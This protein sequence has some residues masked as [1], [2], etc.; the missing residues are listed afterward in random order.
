MKEKITTSIL[1]VAIC[2]TTFLTSPT[3]AKEPSR[4]EPPSDQT[5]L[6]LMDAKPGKER[7]FEL[8][9]LF[10]KKSPPPKQRPGLVLQQKLPQLLSQR[11]NRQMGLSLQI[12]D[13]QKNRFSLKIGREAHWFIAIDAIKIILRQY[14]GRPIIIQARPKSSTKSTRARRIWV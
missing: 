14:Y 7:A 8:V 3:Q 11:S 9:S 4:T 13:V 10:G 5:L 2:I 6:V 12:T 1:A